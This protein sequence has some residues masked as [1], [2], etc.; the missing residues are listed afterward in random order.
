MSTSRL[1]RRVF[2]K[3]SAALAAMGAGAP[4]VWTGS[5]AGAA[6]AK[7][8]R[9]SVA[10][11]GVGGRGTA[12]GNQAGKLGD[13]IA[14][15]DVDRPHAEKFAAKFG[16]RCEIY[17]DYRELLEKEKPDVV[18]IGTP[19]HWHVAVAIAR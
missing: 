1:S 14:C 10:S 17:R 4:Y 11:I 5:S 9:L 6:Q 12:V 8:A 7:N 15:C 3:R 2:L 16:S 19:D 13:M 18:T